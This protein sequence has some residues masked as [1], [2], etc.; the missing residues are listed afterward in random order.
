VHGDEIRKYPSIFSGASPRPP[1]PTLR[2][3]TAGSAGDQI[4]SERRRWQSSSRERQVEWIDRIGR[5]VDARAAEIDYDG[6]G[7]GRTAIPGL[8]R[9]RDQR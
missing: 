7:H 3:I 5:S 9:G 2:V 4:A 8:S 1:A 6:S